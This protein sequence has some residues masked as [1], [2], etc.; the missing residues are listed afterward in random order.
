MGELSPSTIV[1]E[2]LALII[3]IFAAGAAIEAIM[4]LP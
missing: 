2:A 1:A 4:S 3:A